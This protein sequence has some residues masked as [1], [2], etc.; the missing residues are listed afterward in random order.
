VNGKHYTFSAR[1]RSPTS[2]VGYIDLD[3]M[4]LGSARDDLERSGTVTAA[5]TVFA[6]SEHELTHLESQPALLLTLAAVARLAPLFLTI[7]AAPEAMVPLPIPAAT[8]VMAPL[9]I[10]AEPEAKLALPTNA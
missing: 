10:A 4:D 7:P 9:P 6:S 5:K 3:G 1:I 8:E 2:N